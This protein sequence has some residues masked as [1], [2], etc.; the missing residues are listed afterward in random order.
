MLAL[1]RQLIKLFKKEHL[2]VSRYE[3]SHPHFFW[4]LGLDAVLSV[5]LVFGA[6]YFATSNNSVAQ[7]LVHVGNVAMSAD[8]FVTHIK[9]NHVSAFW[10]GPIAGSQY[11]VNHMTP[12]MT[13]VFYTPQGSNVSRLTKFTYKITKYQNQSV[14]TKDVQPFAENFE[15]MSIPVNDKIVL[16]INKT[17]MQSE[18]VTYNNQPIVV[19]VTYP[20]A[21]TL[22]TMIRNAQLLKPVK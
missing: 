16:K 17:S 4:Y 15:D 10:L 2:L 21:Q 7:R 1:I 13:E 20:N 11:S 3:R 5:G 9:E 18:L 8:K 22:K 19:T 6:F 12:G 14:Y